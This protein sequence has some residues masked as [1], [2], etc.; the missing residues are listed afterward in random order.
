MLLHCRLPGRV[1]TTQWKAIDKLPL[2]T[3]FTT[4]VFAPGFHYRQFS[5][6]ILKERQ[7]GAAD[8]ALGGAGRATGRHRMIVTCCVSNP[9]RPMASRPTVAKRSEHLLPYPRL[10]RYWLIRKGRHRQE[11]ILGQTY[12]PR[13]FKTTVVPPQNDIEVCTPTV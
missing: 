6:G 2:R 9:F 13:K 1:T 5:H 3:P 4:A 11:P 10:S 7:A 8:A 12:L